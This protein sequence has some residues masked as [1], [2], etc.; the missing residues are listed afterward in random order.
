MNELLY[1][2]HRLNQNLGIKGIR[3]YS[4]TKAKDFDFLLYFF[5]VSSVSPNST[6]YNEE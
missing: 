1:I 5:E 6:I 3:S 4:S 2:S